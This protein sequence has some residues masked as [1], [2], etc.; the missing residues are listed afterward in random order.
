MLIISDMGAFYRNMRKIIRGVLSLCICFSVFSCDDKVEN[1]MV[2]LFQ[3]Q[4]MA[5]VVA[6]PISTEEFRTPYLMDY[7]DGMLLLGDI[8]QPKFMS[9]FDGL[10]GTFLGDFASRGLGPDEFIHLGNISQVGNS[11]CLWDAGRSSLVFVEQDGGSL[12]YRSVQINVDDSLSAAFQ[13]I[14]LRE[15]AFLASG[16]VKGHRLAL[17][18]GRGHVVSLFGHYP[19]GY[20]RQNTDAENGFIYQGTMAYQ[21][22]KGVLAVACGMG[23]SICFYDMNNGGHLIKEYSFEHP[24]Y[25]LTGDNVSPV[26]FRTDNKTGFVDLKSS[27]NYCIGLFSGEERIGPEDYGGNKLLLFAWNGEPAKMMRLEGKY[28][29]MAIDEERRRILLLG[30]DS[31]GGGYM[32]SEVELP[33]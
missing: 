4:T 10:K 5:S 20:R 26:V 18:D 12:S 16:I 19:K 31:D 15:D 21:E 3:D 13:V 14:P 24:I 9:V 30:V 29:N 11:L 28:T 8:H 25:E 7:K 27:T 17:L 22:K 33:N 32:L 23:E 1:P 6:S 2:N